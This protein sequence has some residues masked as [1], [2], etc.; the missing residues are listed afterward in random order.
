MLTWMASPREA[1]VAMF[2]DAWN[3]YPSFKKLPIRNQNHLITLCE[4]GLYAYVR[5]KYLKTHAEL[6]WNQI[7]TDLYSSVGASILYNLD[8]N[9][10]VNVEWLSN[11][12]ADVRQ[13][14]PCR[15]LSGYFALYAQITDSRVRARV[16]PLLIDVVLD[17]YYLGGLTGEQMNSDLNRPYSEAI[18]ERD[19]QER[20]VSYSTMWECSECHARKTKDTSRQDRSLDECNT[21]IRECLGC[22][23]RWKPMV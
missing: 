1:E 4:E 20:Q 16:R 19:E 22:R 2:R 9:S 3:N 10:S 17:P 8:L 5:D 7:F 12:K 6:T 11:P 18:K 23:K 13:S 21:V 15:V 14:L